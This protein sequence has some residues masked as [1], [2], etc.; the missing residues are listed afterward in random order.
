MMSN[1]IQFS[2][3]KPVEMFDAFVDKSL[4]LTIVEGVVREYQNAKMWCET[5]FRFPESADVLAHYRRACIESLLCELAKQHPE[6]RITTRVNARRNCSHRLVCCGR[7]ILT[8]SLVEHEG[9]LP[10]E[11]VYREGYA[12]DPQLYLFVEKDLPQEDVSL[13][14]IITHMP[15]SGKENGVPAFVDIVFPDEEYKVILGR[16]PLL[17]RFP[18]VMGAIAA[19]AQETIPD[20]LQAKLRAREEKA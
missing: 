7:V 6:F 5:E 18:R 9:L 19:T 20:T 13:Y 2:P 14:G 11:A 16:I 1:A 3:Y 12:R 17:D 8:Q 4:Q 15:L 10:R